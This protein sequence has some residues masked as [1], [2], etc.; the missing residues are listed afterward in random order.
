MT[1]FVCQKWRVRIARAVK[2]GQFSVKDEELSLSF[3]TCAIGERF[4][5]RKCTNLSHTINKRLDEKAYRLGMDFMHAVTKGHIK[6]AA[7]LLTRIEKL[8]VR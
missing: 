5:I 8:P 3:R 2:R 1:Q 6:R 4:K 7:Q